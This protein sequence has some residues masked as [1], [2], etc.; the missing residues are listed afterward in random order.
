MGRRTETPYYESRAEPGPSLT[1][2]PSEKSE[3]KEPDHG[4][5]CRSGYA[6]NIL[7]NVV[8]GFEREKLWHFQLSQM[9]KSLKLYGVEG[10]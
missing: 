6:G 10:K 1:R 8:T 5:D 2:S 3:Y 9:W 4:A 7:P